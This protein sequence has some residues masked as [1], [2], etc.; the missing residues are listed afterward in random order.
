MLSILSPA[1]S[2]GFGNSSGLRKPTQALRNTL[3]Y[4]IFLFDTSEGKCHGGLQNLTWDTVTGDHLESESPNWFSFVVKRILG[5]GNERNI[6]LPTKTSQWMKCRCH[7]QLGTWSFFFHINLWNIYLASWHL[8]QK[9]LTSTNHSQ[10]GPITC[11]TLS[12]GCRSP[13]PS[14]Q[15]IITPQAVKLKLLNCVNAS[16]ELSLFPSNI[17]QR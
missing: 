4:Y 2:D 5:E 1:R 6:R 17:L 14:S 15:A 16:S 12:V 10:S 3:L 11:H 7:S 9:V 8:I 13:L